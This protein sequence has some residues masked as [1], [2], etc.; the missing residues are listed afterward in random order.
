VPA[1]LFNSSN[2]GNRNVCRLV[3]DGTAQNSGITGD[4]LHDAQV[5]CQCALAGAIFD[6]L[7]WYPSSHPSHTAHSQV[8][9]GSQFHPRLPHVQQ[10][11]IT[12]ATIN[13][14]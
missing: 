2:T 14:V 5:G 3:L 6:G 10:V 8:I 4:V 11:K 13:N 12:K 7:S 9:V 1:T